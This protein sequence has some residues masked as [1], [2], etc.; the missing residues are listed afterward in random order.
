MAPR[1]AERR[2]NLLND[3]K[4]FTER[5]RDLLNDAAFDG[6]TLL[7]AVKASRRLQAAPP[8]M[9]PKWSQNGG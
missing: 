2:R 9:E 7:S 8:E 4:R 3:A 1:F 5:C 6:T